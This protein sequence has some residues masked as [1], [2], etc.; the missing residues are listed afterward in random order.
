M[1]EGMNMATLSFEDKMIVAKNYFCKKSDD[2]KLFDEYF[3]LCLSNVERHPDLTSYLLQEADS[4]LQL[5]ANTVNIDG[6]IL[7]HINECSSRLGQSAERV[8]EEKR[9]KTIATNKNLLEQLDTR[10]K[11][12]LNTIR[13]KR[14]LDT[15]LKDIDSLDEQLC[16]DLLSDEQNQSYQALTE[17]LSMRVANIMDIFNRKKEKQYNKR[18]LE[19][20]KKAFETC[21]EKSKALKKEENLK[22][23]VNEHFTCIDTGRLFPETL[24]F[25]N[26]VYAYIF[27]KLDNNGKMKITEFMIKFK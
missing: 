23:F 7:Q 15:I 3:D 6:Q 2:V 11:I 22:K 4:T 9:V 24:I 12:E 21:K 18:A 19:S 16:K 17:L 27:D 8:E 14:E 13:T 26:F 1:S 20:Y 5:F 25:Y 10:I